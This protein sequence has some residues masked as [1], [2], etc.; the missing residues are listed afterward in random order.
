VNLQ[1]K[2]KKFPVVIKKIGKTYKEV[3]EKGIF[4]QAFEVQILKKKSLKL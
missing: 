3:T 1:I 4:S 2:S